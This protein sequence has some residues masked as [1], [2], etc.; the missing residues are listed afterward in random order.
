MVRKILEK[1]GADPKRGV[2]THHLYGNTATASVGL[3]MDRLL[4]ERSVGFGDR[5]VLGSAAAGFAMVVATG[6]WRC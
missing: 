6:E 5:F 2:Y 4:A 3:A 1:I